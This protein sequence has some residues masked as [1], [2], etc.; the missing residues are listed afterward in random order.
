MKQILS[1]SLF[2]LI[3]NKGIAQIVNLGNFLKDSSVSDCRKIDTLKKLHEI[4]IH[5]ILPYIEYLSE[6]TKIHA[7]L[8]ASV[9]GL[10]YLNRNDFLRDLEK[11]KKKLKCKPNASLSVEC[12][13]ENDKSTSNDE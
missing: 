3:C 13:K 12:D 9:L 5:E 1:Y 8:S 4:K 11:W 7:S 10:V 6:K 2:F